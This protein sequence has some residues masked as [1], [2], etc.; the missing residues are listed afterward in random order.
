[1]AF[2]LHP[3][4]STT[5]QHRDD[6]LEALRHTRVYKD[7]SPSEQADLEMFLKDLRASESLP[8][9]FAQ[10]SNFSGND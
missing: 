2:T 9:P 7:A 6:L 5:G 4:E 10:L 8:A 3:G 1:M